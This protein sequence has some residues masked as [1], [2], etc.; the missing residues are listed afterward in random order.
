MAMGRGG[1]EFVS[2]RD[3]DVPRKRCCCR[4]LN[5]PR[6]LAEPSLDAAVYTRDGAVPR[7]PVEGT[8]RAGVR[9]TPPA[10]LVTC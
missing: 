5:W 7:A 1:E 9:G 2:A 4:R 8:R 10:V 3:V 6:P